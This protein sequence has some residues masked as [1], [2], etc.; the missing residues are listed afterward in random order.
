MHHDIVI[1]N[2]NT[3]NNSV[4]CRGQVYLNSRNS[5]FQKIAKLIRTRCARQALKC[6]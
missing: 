5:K 3:D 2:I 1:V 6:T 4:P